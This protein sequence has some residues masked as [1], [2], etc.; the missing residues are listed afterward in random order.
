MENSSEKYLLRPREDGNLHRKIVIMDLESTLT[1]VEF[2]DFFAEKKGVLKEVKA[3]T[4]RA[5]NGEMSYLETLKERIALTSPTRDEI[6]DIATEY[7]EKITPGAVELIQHLTRLGLTVIGISGGFEDP[8]KPLFETLGIQGFANTLIYDE[9]GTA[10]GVDETNPLSGDNGKVNTT[11]SILEANK[12]D[13]PNLEIAG[14]L[15]DGSAGRDIKTQGLTTLYIGIEYWRTM[16]ESIKEDADHVWNRESM[17]EIAEF[18]KPE[19]QPV[20]R[21]TTAQEPMEAFV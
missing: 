3:I 20:V 13:N 12:K 14:V 15:D 19:P 4:D 9:G 5:M 1:G 7:L 18:F 16:G 8:L 21:H 11:I 2:F 6:I 10:T 17:I